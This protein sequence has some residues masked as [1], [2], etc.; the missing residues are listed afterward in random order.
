MIKKFKLIAKVFRDKPCINGHGLVEKN[1]IKFLENPTF[2]LNSP[3]YGYID[4]TSIENIFNNGF[5]VYPYDYDFVRDRIRYLIRQKAIDVC[6]G[7]VN[8]PETILIRVPEDKYYIGDNPVGEF[9]NYRNVIANVTEDL[10]FEYLDPENLGYEYLTDKEKSIA[11]KLYIGDSSSH[12]QNFT[13]EELQ[14]WYPIYHANSTKSRL[15]RIIEAETI[16]DRELPNYKN[17]VMTSLTSK[18]IEID[19][20]GVGS[21][22]MYCFDLHK[23]Y[24]DFGIIWSIIDYNPIKNPNP[25]FG[26][27]DYF[28]STSIF[29]GQGLSSMT[30][31]GKT[32]SNDEIV[33]KMNNILAYGIYW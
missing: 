17:V 3:S 18:V 5:D 29:Q 6:K 25:A 10:N 27:L 21:P 31:D 22:Q 16:I 32:L 2:E 33:A 24:K 9:A 20:I 26:I 13:T 8:D 7:V 12:K 14:Q 19:L 23:N 28:N 30:I 15:S 11:A 1:P 4:V